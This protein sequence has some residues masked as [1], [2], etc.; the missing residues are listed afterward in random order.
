MG[1]NNQVTC[2]VCHKT[3]R[4]DTLKR[5]MKQHENKPESINVVTEKIDYHS[6]VDVTTLKNNIVWR[7][8]EYQ[9]ILELC[10]EV[11]R[12]VQELNTSTD[13]DKELM[14]ALELYEN[15]GHVK[16]IYIYR[17]RGRSS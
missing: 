3:M 13:E 5:H 8:N 14:D 15:N 2:N 1:R 16:P 4:G 17:W 9:R 12:I 6:T 10:R 11:E 7:V